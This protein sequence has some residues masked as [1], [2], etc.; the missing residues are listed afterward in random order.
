M[1]KFLYNVEEKDKIIHKNIEEKHKIKKTNEKFMGRKFMGTVP[2]TRQFE[3]FI[4][5][6]CVII[7]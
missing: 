4:S 7:S 1:H 2:K 3:L 6:K 5:I